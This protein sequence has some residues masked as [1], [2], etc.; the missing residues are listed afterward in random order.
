[1]PAEE[2]GTSF[3]A[4]FISLYDEATYNHFPEESGF[5]VFHDDVRIVAYEHK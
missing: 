5:F 4:D 3:G 2:S 1:M